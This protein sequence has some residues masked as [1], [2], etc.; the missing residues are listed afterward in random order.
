M[1]GV[2]D[3]IQAWWQCMGG[4]VDL[5]EGISREVA[6]DK[7]KGKLWATARY[8]H[9]WPATPENKAFV[10]AF[11]KRWGRFPNYSA[12]VELLIDL[13]DQGRSR[14]SEDH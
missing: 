1:L 10:D 8:I 4:S 11:R 3:K 2:F 5:L 6:A 13:C 7:F 9:N 12:E 14:K